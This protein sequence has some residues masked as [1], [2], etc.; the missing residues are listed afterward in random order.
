MDELRPDDG[1]KLLY[2]GSSLL[3]TSHTW[4]L[5]GVAFGLPIA[6]LLAILS[7]L[8]AAD[9]PICPA[10]W[11]ALRAKFIDDPAN[12]WLLWSAAVLVPFATVVLVL[13]SRARLRLTRTGLEASIPRL[14]GLG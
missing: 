11:T 4:A 6:A 9:G 1:G 7:T 10:I 2:S 8:A 12:R 14:L 13:E 3:K 5:L